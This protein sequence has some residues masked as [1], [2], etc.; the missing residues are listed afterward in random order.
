MIGGVPRDS[1]VDATGVIQKL[2][3]GLYPRLQTGKYR[4]LKKYSA[5]RERLRGELLFTH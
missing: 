5:C 3:L 1:D 2:S 4:V